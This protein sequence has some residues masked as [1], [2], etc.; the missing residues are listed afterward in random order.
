[1]LKSA[2]KNFKTAIINTFQD[3][4]EKI[5]TVSEQME[6][7]SRKTEIIYMDVCVYTGIL[8]IRLKV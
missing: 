7:L 3:L 5:N 6:Q 1:M 2:D 8:H 4:R